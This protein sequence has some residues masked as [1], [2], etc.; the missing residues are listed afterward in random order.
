MS[1]IEHTL[2]VGDVVWVKGAYQDFY[3]P[4]PKKISK[5]YK[6][7]RVMVEGYDHQ[8]NVER[9]RFWSEGE[10]HI[11]EGWV[12]DE[13]GRKRSYRY[14]T[15]TSDKKLFERNQKHKAERDERIALRNDIRPKIEKLLELLRYERPIEEVRQLKADIDIAFANYEK[16]SK[17]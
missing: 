7:G 16:S 13:A 14:A 4:E 2:K 5:V 8:W 15:A 12:L 9:A 10:Y 11:G 6:N 3:Q 1:K 17:A